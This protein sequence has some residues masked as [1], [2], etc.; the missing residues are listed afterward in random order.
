[1]RVSV[2]GTEHVS[3]ASE[4]QQLLVCRGW[5]AGGRLT[6]PSM[7]G[8]CDVLPADYRSQSRGASALCAL[9]L[10]PMHHDRD[11]A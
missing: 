1:M 7:R 2:E 4:S 5:V 9:P 10:P 11:D 3:A 8:S 6:V